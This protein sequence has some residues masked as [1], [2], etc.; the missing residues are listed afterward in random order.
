ME[1]LLAIRLDGKAAKSLVINTNE[2]ILFF[3]T[4]ARFFRPLPTRP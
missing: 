1:K 2:L 4:Y 3:K